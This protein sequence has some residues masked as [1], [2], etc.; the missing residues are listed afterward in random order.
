MRKYLVLLLMLFFLL[1]L[2]TAVELPENLQK[3]IAYNNEQAVYY[4]ETI[5]YI[6]AFLG[7]VLAVLSPCTL[8]LVPMYFSYGLQ[9]KSTRHTFVFFLGFTLT[10][11]LLGI[12][13]AMLGQ[14]ILLLQGDLG[15]WVFFAGL[16]LIFFGVMLVLGKGFSFIPVKVFRAKSFFGVFALGLL[17]ALGWTACTGPILA[18]VLLIAS[19]LGSY[20]KVVL[21]MVLY[22]L[23]NFVPFFLLSFVVDGMRLYEKPW[24]RGKVLSFSL[25]GKRFE[26]HT[27][28]IVSG[29]LLIGMGLLFV[30]F[31][32]T[33]VFNLVNVYGL[34]LKGYALQE[35][36]FT[37]SF[38]P[39]LGIVVLILFVVVL[40]CFLFRRKGR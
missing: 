26:T 17:F 30:L 2:V 29:S 27:T 8:A 13:A 11:V 1:G 12:V 16:L 36:L 21:L 34:N 32:E 31:R 3:I 18:G 37:S 7:G 40:F 35:G 23:G 4:L 25:F 33:G 22:A 6:V 10:F 19:V 38:V 24:V 9:E 5:T 39:L 28:Q 14:S 20:G 15:L